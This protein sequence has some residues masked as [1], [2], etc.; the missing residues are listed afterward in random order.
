MGFF[1][2]WRWKAG[3]NLV[4]KFETSFA[5]EVSLLKRPD[6]RGLDEPYGCQSQKS[7]LWSN[8]AG[9]CCPSQQHEKLISRHTGLSHQAFL[10]IMFHFPKKMQCHQSRR[11][12]KKIEA[13]P[14]GSWFSRNVGPLGK[15]QV[16]LCLLSFDCYFTISSPPSSLTLS[17]VLKGTQ[18]GTYLIWGGVFSVFPYVLM[19][20]YC[21]LLLYLL[22]PFRGCQD[23]PE[24]CCW[25]A[26][27][28]DLCFQTAEG[29]QTSSLLCFLWLQNR[30]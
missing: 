12:R 18:A 17:A 6:N 16:R 4:E 26:L 30:L 10:R 23:S 7:T 11:W 5:A 8:R 9:M 1:R 14:N 13:G 20:S 3:S 27:C 24:R 2:R 25:D 22:Y 19:E 15:S 21:S 28:N 29:K